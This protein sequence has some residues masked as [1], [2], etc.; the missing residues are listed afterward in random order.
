MANISDTIQA[1]LDAVNER[2]ERL[3]AELEKAEAEKRDIETAIRVLEGVGAYDG[4]MEIVRA[5]SRSR[6]AK[7]KKKLMFDILG[8]GERNGKAPAEVYKELV[9][10]GV[11]DINIGTVRTTLWRAAD[12]GELES[13]N[14]S[15]WKS[16]A[17]DALFG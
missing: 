13:A 10:S 3:R 11:E 2:I 7:E 8:V 4:G 5:P 16:E 15:Y 9:A 1:K 14:G 17:E 12:S 6:P